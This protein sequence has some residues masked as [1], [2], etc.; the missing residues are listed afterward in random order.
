MPRALRGG[1]FLRRGNQEVPL[2]IYGLHLMNF[3]V[4]G[5]MEVAAIGGWGS[6]SWIFRILRNEA[7]NALMVMPSDRWL[8]RQ[9][10]QIVDRSLDEPHRQASSGARYR[11]SFRFSVPPYSDPPE[12]SRGPR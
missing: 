10:P 5:A 9:Y 11:L 7:Q 12:S 6:F 8:V 3:A 4:F 1:V 2:S